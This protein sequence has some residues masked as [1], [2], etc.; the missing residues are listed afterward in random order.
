ML[1][2]PPR[3]RDHVSFFAPKDSRWLECRDP[4]PLAAIDAQLRRHALVLCALLAVTTLW[5]VSNLALGVLHVATTNG[6]VVTSG[7]DASAKI[8]RDQRG[9]PHIDAAT[10]HDLFFAQGFAQASDRLFQMDL[11]RR[12]AYGRLSELFGERALTLDEQMRAVDIAGI[13][14]RQW[15]G[16]DALTRRALEAFS[17]G[18]NAA[19]QTQPLPVEFRMLLYQPQPWTPFDSIAIAAMAALEL[20]DS[21]HDVLARDDAWHKLGEACYSQAFPLSDPRYDVSI[22][23]IHSTAASPRQHCTNDTVVALQT[24]PKLGSNA[25]AAGGT[26]TSDGGALIANDPHVDI[27]I[28][29]IWYVMELHAPGFHAA[30]AT[31]PGLPGIALGHNEHVAWAATNAQV[32]TT[33]VYRG[34]AHPRAAAVTERF[35]IRFAFDAYKTYY[36]TASEYYVTDADATVAVRWPVYREQRTTITTLLTLDASNNI[37]GAMRALAS[38]RGAP[39]NFIVADRTGAVAYHLAGLIPLDTAWGRYAHPLAAL[40]ARP[41]FIAFTD[42]PHRKQ[43]RTAILL[44]ANNR[45]YGAGYRYRLSA[46]FE[47]PYRAARIASLLH[48]RS[49]YDVSYFRAMQNDTFSPLDNEIVRDLGLQT[50]WNG[51][52][53]PDSRFASL[54]YDLRTSLASQNIS[55][56]LLLHELRNPAQRTTL[57]RSAEAM[58]AG[59]QSLRGPW[60]ERGAVDVDHPL[61]PMWYG[62]LRGRTLP[63]DGN[64]YTI[65]LQESGFA[66]GFRAV[67]DVRDWDSGG[68]SIPA[69]ESGEAGSPYYD[70]E[71]DAWIRGTLEPLAFSPEAVARASKQVLML[72]PR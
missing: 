36:R 41:R 35:H 34:A 14:H 40:S 47:A 19:L 42:L 38:Y 59:D 23:G 27:S 24:R 52:F 56:A 26:R 4:S 3:H 71:A 53:D 10:M 22:D 39:E 7:L 37:A 48:A 51:R 1:R 63:G 12:Y 68:I 67:W 49:R 60:R 55:L 18:V 46:G 33:Q 61:S 6:T 57:Q 43:S 16:S 72:R 20:S 28:P 45:M 32:A 64:D 54:I 58:I 25:W 15:R 70:D 2:H 9:V 65:R 50:T 66:Q 8:A 29:G 5:Y 69:G 17:N 30:G 11:A 21:W 62:F 44:S 31:I 13:A